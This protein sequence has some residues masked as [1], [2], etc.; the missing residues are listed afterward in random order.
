MTILIALA[1]CF[2][3]Y[4]LLK[5]WVS[6]AGA[7]VFGA[8]GACLGGWLGGLL[9][10]GAALATALM[11]VLAILLAVLGGILAFKLYKVGVF[12]YCFVC[13]FSVG[14]L[15]AILLG[16]PDKWWLVSLILGLAAGVVGVLMTKHIVILSTSL[17][18]GFSA[19]SAIGLLIAGR[20]AGGDLHDAGADRSDRRRQ[21][22]SGGCKRPAADAEHRYADHFSGPDCGRSGGSVCGQS[23]TIEPIRGVPP[24]RRRQAGGVLI[25][26]GQ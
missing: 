17:S 8:L 19:G 6:V 21:Q 15:V 4:R 16:A 18:G 14:A 13:G 7:L 2:F 25:I 5:F 11:W 23:W 3:G 22:H 20:D 12:L 9:N 1:T 26:N 10:G 24:K